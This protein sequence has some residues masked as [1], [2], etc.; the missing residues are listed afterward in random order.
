VVNRVI[1]HGIIDGHNRAA[2]V[3]EDDFD[4][5]ADETFPEDF[6]TGEVGHG[7]TPF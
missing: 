7:G 2:G 4:A 3:A 1:E 6:G 5:F